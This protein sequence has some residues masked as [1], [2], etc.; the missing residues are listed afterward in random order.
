MN[1]PRHLKLVVSKPAGWK[2]PGQRRQEAEAVAAAA[3]T[4]KPAPFHRHLSILDLSVISGVLLIVTTTLVVTTIRLWPHQGTDFKPTA[5]C[6]S[7]QN[8]L[9]NSHFKGILIAYR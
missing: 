7:L 1:K 6:G 3:R 4:V 2:S 9:I 5:I 8:G